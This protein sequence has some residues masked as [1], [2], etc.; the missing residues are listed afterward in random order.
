V[1]KQ[2]M[3]QHVEKSDYAARLMEVSMHSLMQASIE[4]GA[5][6]D[7]E[8]KALSQMRSANKKHGN[9]GD[10]E[11]LENREIVEAWDAKYGKNYLRDEIDEVSEKLSHHEKVSIVG[12]V[13]TDKPIRNKEVDKKIAD[14]MALYSLDVKILS[15]DEWIDYI[16]DRVINTGLTSREKLAKGW[17]VA[18]AES[19]A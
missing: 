10:I 7:L 16:F 13:T 14:V 18:Y 15:L 3:S 12:F 2:I 1:I 9:V 6:G 19:L 4:T 17:L 8:L 5:F 11:L